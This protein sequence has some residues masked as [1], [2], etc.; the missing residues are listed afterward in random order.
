MPEEKFYGG[1]KGI[2]P[3]EA[4]KKDTAT[5]KLQPESLEKA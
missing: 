2:D 4:L 1:G 5:P 3:K